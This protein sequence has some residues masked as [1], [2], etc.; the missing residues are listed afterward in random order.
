MTSIFFVSALNQTSENTTKIGI[1]P[2][3]ET[4]PIVT[5]PGTKEIPPPESPSES[6]TSAAISIQPIPSDKNQNVP[7][8]EPVVT[9]PEE[10]V[11]EP[12]PSLIF[13]FLNLVLDKVKFFVGEVIDIKATLTDQNSN[14]LTDKKV[15]F[16]ADE[17]IIGSNA[18]DTEGTARVAWNTSSWMPGVYTIKA[19]YMD[20]GGY[21]PISKNTSITLIEQ[22]NQTAIPP[23]DV[24]SVPI[25]EEE[26][27]I[28]SK[29]LTE[30]DPRTLENIDNYLKS[31][32][33]KEDLE[34]NFRLKKILTKTNKKGDLENVFVYRFLIWKD[35][36][37]GVKTVI[38]Y[39]IE[40]K[41]DES[42]VIKDVVSPKQR[43]EFLK[44]RGIQ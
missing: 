16:Y 26:F 5:D 9:V 6:P 41:T 25:F 21:G 38:L 35:F 2:V 32:V 43:Y 36:H 19:N 31:F 22:V 3:E 30:I 14:P 17:Q 34:K 27:T 11:E 28:E 12:A 4:T 33:N 37:E 29:R 20:D 42:G 7:V 39:P 18:T 40:I 13:T 23:L 15:D 1:L 8:N 24:V 44:A 10:P